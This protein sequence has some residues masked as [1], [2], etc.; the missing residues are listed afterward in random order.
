MSPHVATDVGSAILLEHRQRPSRH[1][2]AL[3]RGVL[4]IVSAFAILEVGDFDRDS[5][6]HDFFSK[7]QSFRRAKKTRADR[8][9]SLVF[10]S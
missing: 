8:I 3:G 4:V 9:H 7:S 2:S 5:V 10:V 1:D 6:F